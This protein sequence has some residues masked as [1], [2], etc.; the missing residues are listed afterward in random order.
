VGQDRLVSASAW[1]G[2]LLS[3]SAELLSRANDEER[4]LIP[5][6]QRVGRWLGF[7]G[8]SEAELAAVEGRLGRAL[9]PS[10]RS[11]LEASNG[12][13]RFGDQ[14]WAGMRSTRDLCWCRDNDEAVAACQQAGG[15]ASALYGRCLLLTYGEKLT[16]EYWLLDPGDVSA[17]GEWAAYQWPY[18]TWGRAEQRYASFA[19]LAVQARREWA[20]RQAAPDLIRVAV[21]RVPAVRGP[22]PG[23]PLRAGQHLGRVPLR[24]RSGAFVLRYQDDGDLVLLSNAGGQRVWHSGT[25]GTSFGEVALQHDGNLVIYD[26]GDRAVWASGTNG[27]PGE[28]LR[29]RDDGLVVLEDPSGAVL[30]SAGG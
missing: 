6:E 10:Y 1:R 7:A 23:T 12:W 28:R 20:D 30:W 19:G 25:A 22:V 16:D 21:A 3:Y 17:E 4:A 11:F 15:Q 5:R 18:R 8:A 24:S 14:L 26:A 27:Q 9:P 29:V 2:F 13:G